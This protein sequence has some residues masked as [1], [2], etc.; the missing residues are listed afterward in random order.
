MPCWKRA[1]WR[2][3]PDGW[4]ECFRH[5]PGPGKAAGDHGGSAAG[6]G[7]TRPAPHPGRRSCGMRSPALFRRPGPCC[8]PPAGSRPGEPGA[9]LPPAIQRRLR[10]GGRPRPAG[11]PCRR[12]PGVRLHFLAKPDKESGPLRRGELDFET[13]SSAPPRPRAAHPGPVPGPLRRRGAP[14]PPLCDGTL[15][16][17]RYA[18]ARHVLVSRRGQPHSPIDEILAGQGGRRTITTLVPGFATALALVGRAIWWRRCR[19]CTAPACSAIW[20]PCPCPSLCRGS[21]SPC[22]GTPVR[23]PIRA[24]AGC[25]P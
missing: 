17:A 14:G 25:A 22:S 19:T 10:G 4:P 13:G 23:M 16:V 21:G 6:A 7:G 20:S 9:H 8:A 1:V 2:A 15:T 18:A 24:T 3:P 5:E 12:G 11:A